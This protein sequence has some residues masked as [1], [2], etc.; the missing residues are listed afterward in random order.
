M[1]T[2]ARNSVWNT[3]ESTYRNTSYKTSCF[4]YIGIYLFVFI[5]LYVYVKLLEDIRENGECD[6]ALKY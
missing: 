6:I 2:P 4:N 3:W 5:L 1:L